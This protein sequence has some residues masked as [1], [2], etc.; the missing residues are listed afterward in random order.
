MKINF[1]WK[2]TS[3]PTPTL[4]VFA[5]MVQVL[6]IQVYYNVQVGETTDTRKIE[7]TPTSQDVD[8]IKLDIGR[9]VKQAV[10][11]TPEKVNYYYVVVKTKAAKATVDKHGKKG[12]FG[13]RTIV[14]KIML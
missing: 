8:D 5:P 3:P 9:T 12:R 6:K 10:E 7:I 4:E 14:P 1:E 2:I 13:Y 11:G